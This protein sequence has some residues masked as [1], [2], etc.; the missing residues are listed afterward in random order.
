MATTSHT[1][2]NLL[3]PSRAPRLPSPT[4]SYQQ[5][6]QDQFHNAL[7]LYFNEIDNLNQSL[8]APFGARFLNSVYGSFYSTVD[9]TAANNTTAYAMTMNS[10]DMANGVSVV[11]SSRIT[12]AYPGIYNLQ[13]S[14]QFTNTDSQDQDL[15]IWFRKNGVDIANSNSQFS[16]GPRHGSTDGALIAALNIFLEL[17]ANDY[18]E[19]MWAVSSTLVSIQQIP[20]QTSPVRPVTPSVIATLAFVSSIPE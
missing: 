20:A 17:L 12:V 8:V 10:T 14:T 7:R 9:Q 13:F 1:A 18:V 15:S 11:S 16:I 5:E 4:S 3:R 2:K 19:I 6:N